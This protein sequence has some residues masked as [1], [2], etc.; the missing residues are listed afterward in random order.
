MQ[1]PLQSP[2]QL[3]GRIDRLGLYLL[4]FLLCFG[5]FY[6]LFGLVWPALAAGFGLSVLAVRTFQLGEKR[7]LARREAALRR[8]IGGEMA[9]DSLLLQ[10]QENAASNAASW[11]TQALPLTDFAPRGGG[12]L[13]RHETGLVYI[14][15]VQKHASG[16]AG[17]DD[18]LARVRD[19][20]REDADIC[21]VCST[22]AFKQDA[23]ML[24][25]EMTPKTRL[26]GRDGLIGMAGLSAP[27]TDEQLRTLGKRRRRE[28]RRELITARLL[29]PDKKRR[30]AL[31]GL[32]L[33]AL[34]LFTRQVIYVIPAV[35]CLV[36]FAF[37]R[38]KKH[39]K[40]S[41]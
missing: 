9:V 4:T 23:V 12:V 24:A 17:C 26:L 16:T 11:L 8:R 41:L 35:V 13:A 33:S 21:I 15:C 3:A 19:A 5:W 39:A 10:S 32:G 25:E 20:R 28:F 37:C 40:F 27:A 31:Y 7:T 29:N 34:Y 14:S 18:V 1:T 2:T 30:Y 22:C 38:R 36:L 6:A